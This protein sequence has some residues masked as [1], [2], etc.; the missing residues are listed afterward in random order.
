MRIIYLAK[1]VTNQ[2]KMLRI[3]TEFVAISLI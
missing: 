3:G 2:K 1:V